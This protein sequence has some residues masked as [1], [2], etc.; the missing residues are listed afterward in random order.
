MGNDNFIELAKQLVVDYWNN[1]V[2]E[3]FKEGY[4]S[5]NKMTTD[6]VYVV[7]LNKILQNNKAMLS[8]NASD[9]RYYEVTYNGDKNEIY[10]DSYVKEYNEAISVG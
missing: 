2:Y 4:K 8:T 7:W 6:E 3:D 9:G 5:A 1:E 10:F